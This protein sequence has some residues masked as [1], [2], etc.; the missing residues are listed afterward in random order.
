MKDEW[1]TSTVIQTDEETSDSQRTKVLQKY[2]NKKLVKRWNKTEDKVLKLILAL[3]TEVND[4]KAMLTNV[5]RPQANDTKT[6][7]LILKSQSSLC[8]NDVS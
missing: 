4:L 3:V 2:N 6:T 8:L 5:N 7:N 1:E